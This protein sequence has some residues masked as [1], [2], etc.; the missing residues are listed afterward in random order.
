MYFLVRL[1][2]LLSLFGSLTAEAR[3]LAGDGILDLRGQKL[4]GPL[5]LNGDWAFYWQSFVEPQDIEKLEAQRTLITV[6]SVWTNAKEK[7]PT[8]GYASY[9][10][11]VR[12]DAP[13][14]LALYFPA[15][16]WSASRI[17]V[18][19][20]DVAHYGTLGTSADTSTGGQ[21]PKLYA[22]TPKTADFDVIVQAA[23][24]EIFLAGM[25]SS[26]LLGSLDDLTWMRFKKISLDVFIIGALFIMGIYHLCLFWL[27]RSDPSTL[28]FGLLCLGVGCYLTVTRDGLLM[29]L[30]PHLDF[31]L[32]LRLY[33]ITWMGSVPMFTWF[34]HCSFPKHY[35]AWVPL[36]MT[37]VTLVFVGLAG[38]T[39]P[40]F[41]VDKTLGYQ[42][43]T[44]CMCVHAVAAIS[45]A[46]YKKVEGAAYFLAGIMFLLGSYP[47]GK[48]SEGGGT[49]RRHL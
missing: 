6:P 48:G 10:L 2:A 49:D 13:A 40:R 23:N 18:D 46:W 38:F 42:L 36:F 9:H 8:F 22:F 37:V 34:A 15:S 41:F 19:G 5:E 11:R 24:F 30:V 29:T 25:N 20:V 32:R 45:Y 43:L 7:Y 35:K 12:L 33:N 26:P 39:S 4:D 21:G 44:C 28:F 17:I 16:I 3:T 14:P 27:R 31:N 47:H 1:F